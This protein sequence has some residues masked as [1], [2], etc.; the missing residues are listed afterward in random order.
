[1]RHNYCV[2]LAEGSS[3]LVYKVLDGK[4]L[5]TFAKDDHPSIDFFGEN[6]FW[7]SVEIGDQ[8][9]LITSQECVDVQIES[10]TSASFRIV[11]KCEFFT[12]TIVYELKDNVFYKKISIQAE[13]PFFLQQVM[14]EMFR[15]FGGFERG[16]EGQPVFIAGEMFAG[17]EFPSANN[18]YADDQLNFLQ[19]P[20]QEMN[21]GDVFYSFPIVYG[22]RTGK[23]LESTFGKYIQAH[24]LKKSHPLKVYSDWG[25]HDELSDSIIM[26]D[27]MVQNMISQLEYLKRENL[28]EFDYYLMDA[29]WWEEG[30]PY[31][32][33][34]KDC[35]KEGISHIIERLGKNNIQFGLWFDVNLAFVKIPGYVDCRRDQNGRFC[36]ADKK[37]IG[38]LKNAL[39]YH[40]KTNQIKMIKFDFA[41]FDCENPE[42]TFHAK[43]G[44][45]S[46]EPAIRNFIEMIRE[47]RM[48][49][50]DLKILC[51]NGFTTDLSWIGSVVQD[52]KGYAVSPWWAY[53]VDYVYCGDPRASELPSD[54][55]H[56]SLIYYTDAMI[57]QMRNS[58]LPFDSIDSHGVM[59]ANTGT[60]YYLGSAPF[61][62][63]WVMDIS[64]GS[65]KLHFY[66][67]MSLLKPED[68]LFLKHTEDIFDKISSK[69]FETEFIL[70]NPMVGKPYGYSTSDGTQGLITIVNPSNST[71]IV[72]VSLDEWENCSK[73]KIGLWYAENEIQTEPVYSHITQTFQV[74]VGPQSIQSYWWTKERNEN[75]QQCLRLNLAPKESIQFPVSDKV[76]MFSI[77]FLNPDGT[78]IRTG[79]GL[80][81][82]II[83]EY[84]SGQLKFV[85]PKQL[86]SGI[87]WILLK[88]SDKPA[89]KTFCKLTNKSQKKIIVQWKEVTL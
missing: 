56:K 2:T 24:A 34:K 76:Q 46:K 80:P 19:N 75:C 44:V 16:G 45:E 58:A 35:W 26:D 29:F 41:Y 25:L 82:D 84:D 36:I 54:H 77:S 33:F 62:D 11:F 18:G 14:T 74:Q 32:Q 87:S 88:R 15:T 72:N 69:A 31:L 10:V 71:E 47:L 1:M 13:K 27:D 20:Y 7:V 49:E 61:R 64:R 59:C 66:G 73:V 53:D 9:K 60:I 89:E 70:Q 86:W 63:H 57:W 12:A 67:D 81:E 48:I 21:P 55:L 85:S 5:R 38:L 78:P 39:L 42:H 79:D 3:K 6:E 40:I 37:I 30:Q 17:I 50:P 8:T 4:F 28:I 68:H 65:R 22:F 83:L 51:Y 52:R 23:T 43:G